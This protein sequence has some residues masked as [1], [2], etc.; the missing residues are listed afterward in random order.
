MQLLHMIIIHIWFYSYNYI[1]VYSTD[2]YL[3]HGFDRLVGFGYE[4]DFEAD[5]RQIVSLE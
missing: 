3:V 2:W 1:Y 4:Q 5:R